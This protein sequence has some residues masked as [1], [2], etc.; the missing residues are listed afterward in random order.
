MNNI[1][2]TIEAKINSF[3]EVA[4]NNLA[5]SNKEAKR[6]KQIVENLCKAAKLS[7]EEQK[8]YMDRVDNI[9]NLAKDDNKFVSKVSPKSVKV[10]EVSSLKDQIKRNKHKIIAF[11]TAAAVITGAAAATGNHFA[12]INQNDVKAKTTIEKEEQATMDKKFI[13]FN[14]ETVNSVDNALTS[15]I[16]LTTEET[17][18]DTD[19][20]TYAKILTNYRIV[21]N[22]DDFTNLEYAEMF[23]ENNNPTEDLIESFFEYN[24]MIKKHLIIVTDST[25]LNYSNLYN[26]EKDAEVLN[27]SERLIAVMNDSQTDE[28]KLTAAKEWY[29]YVTNMLTST[30]GNI[31]LSSQALD[32]L[33]THSEAYDE[34]TRSSYAN[35]LGAHI[36]DELEHKFNIS[37]AA[38]LGIKGDSNLNVEEENI[39]N[40]KSEFRISFI[41]KLDEKYDNAV[42]E[43]A[44]QMQLGNKLNNEN[45][46]EKDIEYVKEKI[47]LSKYNHIDKDSYIQK[48]INE[49][50]LNKSGKSI[51]DSG[52]SDGNGGIYDK[53]DM[54]AHGVNPSDPNA[55]DKY[56]KAVEEETKKQETE[57]TTNSNG[58][59]VDP[60]EAIKYTN[61]GAN[62]YNNGT[63][64]ESKVPSAY[65]EAYRNGKSAAKEAKDSI[66]EEES[67]TFEPATDESTK[68]ETDVK[69][70]NYIEQKNNSNSNDSNNNDSNIEYEEKFVPIDGSETITDE[71]EITT[72]DYLTSYNDDIEINDTYYAIENNDL[73]ELK[74]FRDQ[75]YQIIESDVETYDYTDDNVKTM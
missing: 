46:Y 44:L 22:M 63:Y 75:L 43:R 16:N 40:L 28:A 64:D 55:A 42:S 51:N 13:K 48:Q 69:T 12:K 30:E 14:T 15:G 52:V 9:V 34:L 33:I 25:R 65:V 50:G 5:F 54:I 66:K 36:D 27:E 4:N 68:T 39:S 35:V 21:A 18:K 49:K 47:D 45:S 71:S 73:E 10:K 11:A 60:N 67:N 6:L 2:E 62:D 24:T 8:S 23:G 61:M 19:K 17:L 41:N 32:T 72:D 57:V 31:A 20:E 37:K 38:C 56:R 59:I 29:S 70:D 7:D 1:K 26:N 3:E 53:S 58:Q 74:E